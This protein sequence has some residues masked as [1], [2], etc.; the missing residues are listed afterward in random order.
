MILDG[1]GTIGKLGG[2]NAIPGGDLTVAQ[3]GG[4]PGVFDRLLA[5]LSDLWGRGNGFTSRPHEEWLD[6]GAAVHAAVGRLAANDFGLHDVAGNVWE[7]CK[8]GYDPSFY[9]RSP[10]EDPLA[11]WE[12]AADRVFRGGSFMNTADLSRSFHRGEG[13]S[14]R[15]ERYIGVRPAAR[16]IMN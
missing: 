16:I 5:N 2:A 14:V 1:I 10:K 6:D 13:P 12:D 4:E 9:G 11:P 15:A 8:D 3:G 7:W